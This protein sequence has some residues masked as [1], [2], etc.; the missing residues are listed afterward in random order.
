MKCA[1]FV[2]TL[3][4]FTWSSVYANLEVYNK[5]KA[6]FKRNLVASDIDTILKQLIDQQ[7]T[8]FKI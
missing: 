4:I 6:F 1:C 2:F 8:I 3:A 5:Y 7:V